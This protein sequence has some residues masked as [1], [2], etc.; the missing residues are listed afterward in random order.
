M[1]NL[2]KILA[3]DNSVPACARE[4]ITNA[5][6][7]LIFNDLSVSFA[8]AISSNFSNTLFPSSLTITIQLC[9][10]MLL[11][12]KLSGILNSLTSSFNKATVSFTCLVY[13]NTFLFVALATSMIYW[14]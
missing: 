2:S 11:V 14:I 8:E 4:A 9:S 12:I 10:N 3:N 6:S 5:S 13:K 1:Y 7:E